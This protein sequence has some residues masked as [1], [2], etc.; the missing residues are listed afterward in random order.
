MQHDTYFNTEISSVHII[1]K[2]KVA[3]AGWR[4][5][6]LKQLHQVKE[7]PMDVSTY[8]KRIRDREK[9]SEIQY[10]T[11]APCII[12]I[13]IATLLNNINPR[14]LFLKSKMHIHK[15][16]ITLFIYVTQCTYFHA[17]LTS[18][19][20]S[21]TVTES[22]SSILLPNNGAWGF[23]Y[24]EC[25]LASCLMNNTCISAAGWNAPLCIKQCALSKDSLSSSILLSDGYCDALI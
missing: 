12:L 22:F 17:E 2:E 9:H 3:C 7:L 24:K 18:G 25:H 4:S 5:S 6:H 20:W 15:E 10:C 14:N 13:Y 21:S 1:A 19:L 8:W 23:S 11:S 16:N